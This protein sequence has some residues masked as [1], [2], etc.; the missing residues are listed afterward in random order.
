MIEV[1]LDPIDPQL[2]FSEVVASL[3]SS[4]EEY[5][6]E[7]PEHRD[8]LIPDDG[9]STEAARVRAACQ[10]VLRL[11]EEANDALPEKATLEVS[12]EL[13]TLFLSAKKREE[14]GKLV[15]AARTLH[16]AY[17]LQTEASKSLG[18][19]N[20]VLSIERAFLHAQV[21]TLREDCEKEKTR[22]QRLVRLGNQTAD[23]QVFLEMQ[24]DALRKRKRE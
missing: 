21:R 14:C 3:V 8:A 6:I 24:L 13:K 18:Q 11:F 2:E 16:S 22:I 10:S 7:H 19:R 9:S 20:K 4:A 23:R 15:F 12:E 1:E 5:L 17:K